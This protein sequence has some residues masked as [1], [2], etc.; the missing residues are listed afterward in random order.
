MSYIF[1]HYGG[2][3]SVSM[4]TPGILSCDDFLAFHLSW[5]RYTISLGRGADIFEG[6]FLSYTSSET[7]HFVKSLGFQS[8]TANSI[9]YQFVKFLGKICPLPYV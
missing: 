8:T 7:L 1:Q 5:N 9:E 6:G 2:N 4:P 3:D